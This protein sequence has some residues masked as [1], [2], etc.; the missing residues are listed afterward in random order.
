MELMTILVTSLSTAAVTLVTSR[1]QYK[2]ETR[3]II[4]SET[5]GM[6][7]HYDALVNQLQ[8]EITRVRERLVVSEQRFEEYKHDKESAIDRLR[9]KLEMAEGMINRM[10]HREQELLKTSHQYESNI[11]SLQMYIKEISGDN[12]SCPVEFPADEI[13]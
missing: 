12:Y 7:A 5:Q 4:S 1:M 3:K 2:A 10:A 11:A 6:Y 9:D 13:D 8:E